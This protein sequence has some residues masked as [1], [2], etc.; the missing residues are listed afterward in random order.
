MNTSIHT[1]CAGRWDQVL[2]AIGMDERV[3]NGRH[4]PCIYCNGTDR[5]RWVKSKQYYQCNQ[6]G[7][8][9]PMNIAIDYLGIG[10]KESAK[11]IRKNI[12]GTHM[13]TVKQTND[14]AKNEARIKSIYAGLKRIT[15]DDP[16]GKYLI[17]RGIKQPPVSG[18]AYHPSVAC[19]DTDGEGKM[20]NRGN[21][22]ALVGVIRDAIDSIISLQ[23]NYLT[24]DGKKL[25]VSAPKKILPLIS[26]MKGAAIRLGEVNQDTQHIAIT[27]GISTGLA[28]QQDNG[29][30]VWCAINANNM[31]DIYIPPHIKHVYIIADNDTSYTGQAKAFE[32]ANRLVVRE[33]RTVKVVQLIAN[34]SDKPLLHMEEPT[35]LDYLDYLTL[36][37]S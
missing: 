27:E 8:H 7:A 28:W 17:S 30:V 21:Y 37:A 1:Q 9:Q 23:I 18:V 5:A 20:F 10:F 33:K 22:P 16:A 24:A 32:L 13:E 29:G 26:H 12:L 19:W 34:G 25:D 2:K 11:Y 3:F 15:A 31:P 35:G 14:T 36:N 4:Q 6:C